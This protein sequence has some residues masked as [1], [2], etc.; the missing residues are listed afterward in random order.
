MADQ[1]PAWAQATIDRMNEDPDRAQALLSLA[2]WPPIGEGF[3][4]QPALPC[5]VCGHPRIDIV[6]PSRGETPLALVTT[7]CLACDI[8]QAVDM[9]DID[10]IDWDHVPDDDELPDEEP[11]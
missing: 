10:L 4:V 11:R 2:G 9:E 5:P 7:G 8:F 3:E 1:L 6:E